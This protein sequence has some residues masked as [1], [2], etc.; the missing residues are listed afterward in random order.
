MTIKELKKVLK[1]ATDDEREVY[2]SDEKDYYT[3]KIHWNFD[4]NND[5]VLEKG[6]NRE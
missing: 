1:L 4:D 5:L 6:V 3:T 2:I